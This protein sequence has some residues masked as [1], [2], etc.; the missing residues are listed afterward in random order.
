MSGTFLF[1]H[2]VFLNYKLV[3][4]AC[5]AGGLR[6][7]IYQRDAVTACPHVYLRLSRYQQTPIH[8]DQFT[9][10]QT[11]R[12]QQVTRNKHDSPSAVLA[13]IT[14]KL[15]LKDLKSKSKPLFY[16]SF[17]MKVTS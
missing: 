5:T 3:L 9:R 15:K 7:V 16:K 4:H 8:H 11:A 12:I 10:H 17:Q 13:Q 6:Q 14:V 1:G 2:G